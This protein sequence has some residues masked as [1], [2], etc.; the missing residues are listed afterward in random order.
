MRRDKKKVRK[1]ER[2][3]VN[4][5]FAKGLKFKVMPLSGVKPHSILNLVHYRF[6]TYIGCNNFNHFYKNQLT[7]LV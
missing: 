1:K 3:A 6:A 2:E 4:N 7:S 5:F